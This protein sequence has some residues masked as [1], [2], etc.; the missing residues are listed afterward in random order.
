MLKG[1]KILIG[2]SG[3]IAAYKTATL[4]RE[5]I[6]AE[7]EVKV[8]MTEASTDFI[9]PLTLSTLSKNPVHVDM[10]NPRNGE[11]DSHVELSLWADAFVI[12][13][14]SANTMA[15]MAHGLCDN[16]LLAVYLSARSPVF[17]APTMD[18]DMY[19]HPTTLENLKRI[20]GFGNHIIHPEKGELA[21]GLIGEGRMAEPHTIAKE[22]S[23]FF[24]KKKSKLSGKTLLLT[25]GPTVEKID[26]VRYISNFSSGKMGY[27]LAEQAASRG[28]SVVLVS[29]P[30]QLQINHPLIEL[31]PVQSAEQMYQACLRYHADSDVSVFC[32]AVCDFAPIVSASQ[33]MKPSKQRATNLSLNPTKD[34]AFELG[35]LKQEQQYHLGFALET[36]N[37]EENARKKLTSKNLNALVL[38]SLADSKA[39]FN[40]DTNTVS[41]FSEDAVKHY[42]NK[43]KSEVAIDILDYIEQAF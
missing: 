10:F 20:Q 22:L 11:W 18:L 27:A 3:G 30:T 13:P 33:K 24:Q 5:I 16:L 40:H 35:K 4:V 29:G 23:R 36:Q 25:A 31:V 39:G 42:K 34:I 17:V 41:I 8:I 26:P 19:Q 38:N 37:E 6:K 2:V 21:S 14:C 15:K 32:A 7:A 12:A 43:L 1:K 28:M 9:T